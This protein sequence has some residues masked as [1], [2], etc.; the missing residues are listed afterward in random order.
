MPKPLADFQTEFNEEVG[1]LSSLAVPGEVERWVNEGRTRIGVLDFK[2]ATVTWNAGDTE[3]TLPSD[4]VTFSDLRGDELGALGPYEVWGNKLLVKR[5]DGAR[6]D[7]SALLLYRAY[8]PAIDAEND[9]VLPE[10]GNRALLSY[11]LYRFFKKLSAS[12][13]NYR[14]YAT[15]V[16]QNAVQI[17]DLQA[18][19]DRHYSDAVDAVDALP[20]DPPAIFYGLG[21]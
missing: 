11:A 16:G 3:V 15:L 4:F 12:R 19:A 17:E 2:T 14:R 9:S 5:P 10:E 7:G 1:D 21:A 6:A 13:V 20:L 18:E 8:F